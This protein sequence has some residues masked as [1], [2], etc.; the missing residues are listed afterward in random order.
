MLEVVNVRSVGLQLRGDQ[1]RRWTWRPALLGFWFDLILLDVV[2]VDEL[3]FIVECNLIR[4]MMSFITYRV[5]IRVL[6]LYFSFCDASAVI[7]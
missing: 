5:T 6:G 3:Q 1:R 4:I 2:R 7:H